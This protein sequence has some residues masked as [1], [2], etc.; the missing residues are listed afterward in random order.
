MNPSSSNPNASKR[1]ATG[2]SISPPPIKRKAQSTI[3]KGAV[4]SFFTPTSQ[5]PKDR[6]IWNER[7]LDDA[8]PATLLVGRY[9]PEDIEEKEEDRK[10]RRKIA[11]FD[12]DSTLIMTSSGKK[13][14]NEAGDW[15]W[16][17]ASVPTRLKKLYKEEG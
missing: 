17:D 3:S 10:G 6:T 14:G 9:E 5:K 1:K 8:S 12:F 13:F 4:A 2:R 7:A 11:A 16:W 15:R